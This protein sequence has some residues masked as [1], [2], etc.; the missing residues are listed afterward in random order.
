MLP[1]PLH[2][3]VVHFPIVLA[4]LLPIVAVVALALMARGRSSRAAWLVPLV[5]SAAMA[6]AAFVALE[7]GQNEEDRVEKVVNERLIGAH[8]EA[9]EQFLI[10]SGILFL[11]TAAGLMRGNVG[12][13]ARV[14]ATVGAFAA[15]FLG[16]RVGKAGGE[17]VYKHG[18]AAA[19]AANTS[20]GGV[21][22]ATAPATDAAQSDAAAQ[23]EGGRGGD[24]DDDD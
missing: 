8:E 17:L 18:A 10:F 12:R 19:Y 16:V 23:P 3:A 9:A 22:N 5:F 14:L 11:V 15:L 1:S 7:T 2:P 24:H 20:G 4:I 21:T 13:S 6:V